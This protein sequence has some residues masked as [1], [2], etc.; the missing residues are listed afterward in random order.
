MRRLDKPGQGSDRRI[1][2]YHVQN[3]RASDLAATLGKTL[4]G[5]SGQ[6]YQSSEP[7]PVPMTAGPP[8]ENAQ[9]SPPNPPAPIQPPPNEGQGVSVG[10]GA[11]MPGVNITADTVNNSLVI[12]A[13]PQQYQT[14]RNALAE[15]DIAP[16]Q[17]FLEAAIAEIT[18]D[19][20]LKFGVQYSFS[21]A[22]NTVTYTNNSQSTAIAPE[23]PG[24]SYIYTNGASIKIILSTIAEKT[25]VNVISSP[26]V[27]VLNN[28]PASLQ[29]GDRVPIVTQQAIST[30]GS[31]PP[32]VNS[33]QYQDTGVILKV[34]PRV[35]AGGLVLMDITQE[36]SDVVNTTTSGID[37]PTIQERKINSA[38]AVQDGETVA[39]GGLIQ[40]SR[41]RGRSGI[42]YLQDIPILGHLFGKTTNEDKR[43]EL[44]VLIT[45]HVVDNLEKARGITDELRHKM[46]T[47]QPLFERGP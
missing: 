47:L 32:I 5:G 39:L 13:T 7:P 33:V 19:D 43:T 36:V 9:G 24:F 12:L 41:S 38:V 30:I 46:P 18:L 35:N 15:L 2:V 37:S 28:Q 25:H 42:P 27:L 29:V 14:I 31:S 23:V 17:V 3:G 34:T 26:K 21:D 11:A 8:G 6:Q 44:M 45:P 20:N 40:D 1:F 22:H 16:L 10:G 4:L